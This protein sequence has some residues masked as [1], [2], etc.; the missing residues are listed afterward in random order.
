MTITLA[1]TVSVVVV[2]VGTVAAKTLALRCMWRVL[3]ATEGGP[4]AA[5]VLAA[6]ARAWTV[7]TCGMRWID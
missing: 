6:A 4:W 2:V 3:R 5:A 7:V 1:V